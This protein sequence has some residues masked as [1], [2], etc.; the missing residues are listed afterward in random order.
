MYYL[1]FTSSKHLEMFFW[2]PSEYW[3]LMDS[4]AWFKSSFVASGFR[5]ML[6]FSRWK[7]KIHIEH[8]ESDITEHPGIW[9]SPIHPFKWVSSKQK[10][11]HHFS[12]MFTQ[13][14]CKNWL[15]N[16]N[17]IISWFHDSCAYH[18]EDD[19]DDD[20]LQRLV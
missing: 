4:F 10:K 17:L 14:Y 18:T 11:I 2:S 13:C 16:W 7:L 19:S 8:F 9:T 1:V 5:K 6:A 12:A 3:F 20:E 15:N